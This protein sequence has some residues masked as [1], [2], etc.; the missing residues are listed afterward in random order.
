MRKSWAT[1]ALAAALTIA[2]FSTVS[3]GAAQQAANDVRIDLNLKDA[4]LVLATRAITDKTALQFVFEGSDQPYQRIT[5][6]LDGVTAEDAIAY[7]CKAAGAFYRRDPNGVY[8]ISHDKQIEQPAVATNVVPAAKHVPIVKVIKL[9]KADPRQ[10]YEMLAGSIYI[11]HGLEDLKKRTAAMTA[12]TTLPQ[13]M[14]GPTVLNNMTPEAQIAIPQQTHSAPVTGGESGNQIPVPGSETA[15]QLGGFGAGGGGGQL[16]GRGGGGQGGGLGGGQNGGLGAGGNAQ[17]TGGTGLVPTGISFVTYDPTTNSLVV[18]ADSEDAILQLQSIINMFD[19]APQQ[20]QIKVEFI[21]T[22]QSMENSLGF[23]FL[24]QRGP[25]FAGTSPGTFARTSDPVFL[26]YATGNITTRLRTKLTEGRGRVVSAPIVRTLNNQPATIASSIT[27]Y[28]FITTTTVS[29]GTVISNTNPLPLTASTVL[30]VAPRINNDQTI[31]VYLTPQIQNFVG[32]S[33][34]P[35]G[36]EIP[37][38]SS[39][40]V[41]VVARVKNGETIVLGGLTT[42]TDTYNLNRVPV[43]GDLPIIG[44]FFRSTV[45]TSSN[46][47]LLIFV[48]PTIVEDDETGGG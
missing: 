32:T 26:N 34:G 22:T 11:D 1:I 10:I 4:D 37:N 12:D 5:L 13:I 43:L 21:T 40:F 7:I 16:G 35:N 28:I 41:S 6:K 23:D 44:Q 42:K 46:S 3:I 36:E 27:T 19:Q 18:Q 45:R 14:G 25:I 29:N 9:M 31:T 15:S 17:L 8:V 47:D 20:V 38:T 48:T 39:Q 33:T 30:S 2:A 24:Y